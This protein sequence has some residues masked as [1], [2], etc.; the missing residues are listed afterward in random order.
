MPHQQGKYDHIHPWQPVVN[1]IP[2]T[3]LALKQT[4]TTASLAV[5]LL[6]WT[7]TLIEW[8]GACGSCMT[9]A[10]SNVNHKRRMQS[11]DHLFRLRIRTATFETEHRGLSQH[12]AIVV[13]QRS[14]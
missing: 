3:Q 4:M 7:I 9:K 10:G 13:D 1:P 14:W 8:K 2:V 5:V 12:S 6:N 11:C